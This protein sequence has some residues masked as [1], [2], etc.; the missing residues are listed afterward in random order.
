VLNCG[1][2][3]IR[4]ADRA[5]GTISQM[6]RARF[7]SPAQVPALA[8]ALALGLAAVPAL[9]QQGGGGGGGGG[10]GAQQGGGA[11]Q[12]PHVAGA[13]LMETVATLRG[14][15]AIGNVPGFTPIVS[16]RQGEQ[17]E[18]IADPQS[19]RLRLRTV[20]DSLWTQLS[21]QNQVNRRGDP[22]DILG[23]SVGTHMDLRANTVLGAL[24]LV[25]LLDQDVG[26]GRAHGA[27][28]LVGL[29][30]AGNHPRPK[31]SYDLA[32]LAG[33]GTSALDPVGTYSDDVIANRLLVTGNLTQHFDTGPLRITPSLNLKYARE[34]WPAY[35][36]GLGYRFSSE[37]YEFVETRARLRMEYA[38][39]PRSRSPRIDGSISLTRLDDL[40]PTDRS[41]RYGAVE[42]GLTLPVSRMSSVRVTWKRD[43]IGDTAPSTE[44]VQFR[45]TLRF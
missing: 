20:Q 34:A 23:L 32:V 45:L 18:V 44:D 17:L 31:L 30:V 19:Y 39:G 25:D 13:R 28:W 12:P 33:R 11:S 16:G 14:R 1:L 38:F 10:G 21:Y 6:H 27:G 3:A 15:K 2:S 43:R 22:A 7:R 35:T 5:K 40:S 29:Y 8:L 42:L 24:A 4:D 26:S 36:D 37:T 41:S 9:A